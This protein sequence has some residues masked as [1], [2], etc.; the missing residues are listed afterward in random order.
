MFPGFD[1]KLVYASKLNIA[2]IL[3]QESISSDVMHLSWFLFSYVM[4]LSWILMKCCSR[5]RFLFILC[6]WAEYLWNMLQESILSYYMH[7]SWILLKYGTRNQFQVNLCI[8]AEY[9][10]NMHPGINF[11]LFYA[12]EMNI[13]E[14]CFQ[15]SILSY[16]MY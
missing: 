10:W 16:F 5:S 8:W 14:I 15:E 9:C 7:L 2:E 6:I 12:S 1:F 13:A 3:L 4:H 11:K